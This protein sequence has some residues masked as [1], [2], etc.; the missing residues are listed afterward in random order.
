MKKNVLIDEYINQFSGVT[1]QRLHEIRNLIFEE[2]PDVEEYVGY[3]MPA[4][5]LNGKILIYFAAFKS[6]IGLYATP[7]GHEAFKE[8]LS[9]YKQGKGSVQFPID[10]ELPIELIRR[11]VQFR[12]ESQT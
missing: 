2:I 4:Y 11:I 3:K 1:N 5:K 12:K 7:A 6:H 10:L 8:E 9:T